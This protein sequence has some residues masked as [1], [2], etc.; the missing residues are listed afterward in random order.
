LAVTYDIN[1]QERIIYLTTVGESSFAEWRDMMLSLLSDPTYRR[2]MGFLSDRRRQTGVPEAEFAREAAQFLM[3][4]SDEME[5]CR[6]A[7]VSGDTAI[8]GM[9]RMFTILSETTGVT[10]QAFMD[11]GEARRWLLRPHD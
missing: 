9:Q 10:A 7:A 2:G 8:Y 6:W 11:Y 4:H 3:Q 1:P 5:G